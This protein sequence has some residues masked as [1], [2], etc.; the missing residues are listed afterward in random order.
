MDDG[1]SV[2]GTL[3][4]H[5]LATLLLSEKIDLRKGGSKKHNIRK[6]NIRSLSELLAVSMAIQPSIRDG[7]SYSWTAYFNSDYTFSTS[8]FQEH[9]DSLKSMNNNSIKELKKFRKTLFIR[10]MNLDESLYEASSDYKGQS[11]LY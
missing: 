9:L 2:V 8:K 11:K 4:G 6:I 10:M 1:S 5:D 3:L 7:H